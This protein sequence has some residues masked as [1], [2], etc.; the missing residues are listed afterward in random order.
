MKKLLIILLSALSLTAMAQQ[1]KVAVYVT[2]DDAGIN[3]VLGSKLV[4]AIARS[5]EYSAI[6]RTESFLAELNKEQNYQRTGAV[7]DSELSRLG[8]QF[9][10]QYIC[11]ASVSD[12]FNEKYLSARLIDVETAQ[13]ERTASS[14]GAIQSLESLIAAANAVSTELLASLGKSLQSNS[15]KVAVYVVKN[16]A[17]RNIG[18]VLG[19][20]LVA[21][22]TNSGRYIAI[23]RTNSFLTQLNKEQNYQRSGSV[24]DEEIS[25]LGKQFG[26]QYVCVVEISD[27]FDEKYVSARLV[28]VETAKIVNSH[29]ASGRINT[30]RS[31]LKTANQLA[32]AL[33]QVTIEE[34]AKEQARIE[35]EGYVDLGLP[36]GTCWKRTNEV[37]LMTYV[38][39]KNKFGKYLPTYE[40]CAELKKCE[41]VYT[42]GGVRVIGPNGNYFMLKDTEKREKA[43]FYASYL[44]LPSFPT[45]YDRKNNKWDKCIH[46]LC[47]W[48]TKDDPSYR[49]Y[50]RTLAEIDCYEEGGYC[51]ND[52][53]GIIL[54]QQTDALAKRQH[55]DR[56]LTT[57]KEYTSIYT[58]IGE[59]YCDGSYDTDRDK[60]GHT[61]RT[62]YLSSL[63][64]DYFRVTF[65]FKA[66]SYYGID[67]YYKSE[68]E[69]QYPVCLSWPL[70]LCLRNDGSVYIKTSDHIYETNIKYIPNQYCD[71]DIEYYKGWLTINGQKMWIEMYWNEYAEKRFESVSYSDGHSFIGYLK[72]IKI[73][74]VKN[75]D[76]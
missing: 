44:A 17:G 37:G 48:A 46:D 60:L 69:E 61:F 57:K 40:Q 42:D 39:A 11:V 67:S 66:L 13:V 41:W 16:E 1:K 65:S 19:D 38:E 34:Y 75:F 35:R 6:E 43:L 7:D 76:E 73:Y 53:W 2:G 32:D 8:K 56:T 24:N 70:R 68:Q 23:E 51:A 64:I 27:V 55:D 4:S 33:S 52:K 72:D 71:I 29:D 14:S 12:A 63:N 54:C 45:R 21:G 74:N 31:C 36:S 30:L 58:N 50:L 25:R 22:F 3:K 28:D 59:L 47:I 5:N 15:K 10:V 9:G 26:V 49:G 18:R 20:K 62:P